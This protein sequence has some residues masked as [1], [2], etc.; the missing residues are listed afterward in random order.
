MNRRSLSHATH[1]FFTIVL[2]WRNIWR[3]KR[4]SFITIA[5]VFFAVFFCVIMLS[6]ANGIWNHVIDQTLRTQAGHIQIHLKGYWNDK[7]IDNFMEMDSATISAIEALDEV[8]YTSPRVET[9]VMASTEKT[10]KPCALVGI[11]PA[12]ENRMSSLAKHIVAGNYLASNDDGILI[13]KSLSEYLKLAVGDT[14]A[15]IGQ[16]YHGNSAAGLFVVRGILDIPTPD[17][18]ARFIYTSLSKAQHFISFP[19]GES[20]LL[21]TLKDENNMTVAVKKITT[22]IDTNRYE[23]LTWKVT[24]EKLLSQATSDKAFSKLIMLILYV[25]VGFGILSTFIMLANERQR[26]FALVLAL[27]MNRGRLIR[28]VLLELLLMTILGVVAAIVV[29]IP[30]IMYFY[31]HPIALTGNLADTMAQYGMQSILPMDASPLIWIS[32]TII[33]VMITCVMAIYPIQKI[34]KL[35]IVNS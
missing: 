14:I 11:D 32:Q 20:G 7:V 13:G 34:R 35:N 28:S 24:M 31:Y 22:V 8:A 10:T 15:L 21:I 12:R 17:I 5:S 4:R 19:N 6:F 30:I 18:D 9:F 26:E 16:G 25:I 33:I 3:N 29:T 2:P 27:G 23:V 1:S